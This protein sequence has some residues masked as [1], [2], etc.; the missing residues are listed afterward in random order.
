MKNILL[1]RSADVKTVYS[2]LEKLR[3]EFPGAKLH[4]LVQRNMIEVFK[5]LDYLKII[6]YPYRDFNLAAP[7]EFFEKLPGMDLAF[8]LYKNNGDGYEEVDAFLLNKIRSVRYG[9]VDG[10]MNVNHSIATPA[11][12]RDTF[13]KNI[14]RLYRG[15]ANMRKSIAFSR[16]Y[17][18]QTSRV[19]FTG[20][21]QI[22]VDEGGKFEMSPES[23]LRIGHVPPDWEGIREYGGTVIRIHRGATFKCMGSITLYSGIRINIFPGAELSIGDG[24][25]IA[26]NTKIFVEKSIKIGRNCAISWDVEFIDTDFHRMTISDSDVKRAAIVLHDHVWIGAGARI[27]K[28]VKL[29]NNSVV[30]AGS[31]VTK[32]FPLNSIVA[33]NP[34][35]LVGSKEGNYRV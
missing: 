1:L 34:A 30:A 16:K 5:G 9:A 27:L 18:P 26:F 13:S 20:N 12:K 31:V 25:Y 10:N 17:C 32:N 2:A 11:R 24:T 7:D 23:V 4:L 19:I 14:K 3:A 15:D 28:N 33:G 22:I 8:S 6:E 29:G 21:C 35:K